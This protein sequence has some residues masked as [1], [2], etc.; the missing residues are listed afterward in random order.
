MPAQ[1]RFGRKT[2]TF[3]GIAQGDE[4]V[5]HSGDHNHLFVARG[6]Y[7]PAGRQLSKR[8][9]RSIRSQEEKIHMGGLVGQ[10]VLLLPSREIGPL[11]E[12]KTK[13]LAIICQG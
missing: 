10:G 6:R 9:P 2:V 13:A 11:Q 4:A 8:Y 1:I 12:L 7:E 3:A 5:Q